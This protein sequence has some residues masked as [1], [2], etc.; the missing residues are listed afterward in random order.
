MSKN[1]GMMNSNDSPYLTSIEVKT[2]EGYKI[3]CIKNILYI[4]A[5]RKCSIV[6]INHGEY[7]IT[8]HL[9]KWYN[10]HLLKPHFFRCHNSYLVNCMFVDYYGNKGITLKNKNKIPLSRNNKS[11]FKENLMI[12]LNNIN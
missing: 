11:A 5:V 7:I 12:F 3:I 1:L 8:Y 9:L 6:H 4:E 2:S 10:K